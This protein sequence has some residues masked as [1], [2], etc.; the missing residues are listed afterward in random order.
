[1]TTYSSHKSA[2]NT[3]TSL[4]QIHLQAINSTCTEP[5]RTIEYF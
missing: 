5:E 3:G 2:Q 1:M 4:L